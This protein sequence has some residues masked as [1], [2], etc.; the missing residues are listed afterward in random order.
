MNSLSETQTPLVSVII[1][2]YNQ[3]KYLEATLRSVLE[4]D[5][6]KIEI[7][8]IDGGSTDGS[9]KILERFNAQLNLWLSEIDNGQA[10]AINKGLERAHGDILGWLNSDDLLL[11]GTISRA[12]SVFQQNPEVDVVYGRL[13]RIDEEGR[14]TPTPD[15]PKD[16]TEFSLDHVLGECIVN[17]PGSFWRRTVMEKAGRLD[18]SLHYVLD[19][20]YWIRLA[21]YGARFKKLPEVVARFRLSP[22]SKTVSQSTAMAN[23]QLKALN[24][25]VEKN[26]FAK[27][28]QISSH[29]VERRVRATRATLC[30]YAFY[31]EWK[32]GRKEPARGWLVKALA[33]KP[34]VLLE[35]RW[36]TLGITSLWR[37]NTMKSSPERAENPDPE[38]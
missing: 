7:L 38:I 33:Y 16:R 31:G 2:S 23:E 8:V 3:A 12:V 30:L 9:V 17:Q 29:E 36:L 4:Q 5:Y 26:D 14:L 32:H 1:P 25:L 19:Y 34:T 13:E 28:L 20:E 11:S 6:P 10:H 15:L 18:I 35:C 21:M 27:L 24:K 22:G 37:Q